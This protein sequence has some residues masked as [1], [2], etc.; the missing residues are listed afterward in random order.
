MAAFADLATTLTTPTSSQNQLS[1]SQAVYTNA[2]VPSNPTYLNN[3]YSNHQNHSTAVLSAVNQFHSQFN[4]SNNTNSFNSFYPVTS[5]NDSGFNHISQ[6]NPPHGK[7][8]LN[9]KSL[10]FFYFN[11][12]L[13]FRKLL[14]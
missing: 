3:S 1:Q 11:S 6:T 4:Q 12:F 13:F 8:F 9:N 5:Q 14:F 7:L 2:P 10:S